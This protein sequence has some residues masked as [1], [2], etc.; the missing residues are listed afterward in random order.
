LSSGPSTEP[1]LGPELA[2]QATVQTHTNPHNPSTARRLS[3]WSSA[4]R[5]AMS[6]ASAAVSGKDAPPVTKVVQALTTRKQPPPETPPARWTRRAVIASFWAVF[7]FLGLP[8]WIK[9]TSIYR[10]VLPL[11]QMT[12]WAEGKV[13]ALGG[14]GFRDTLL[15]PVYRIASLCFLYE[16]LLKHLVYSNGR[17]RTC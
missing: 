14:I 2:L 17:R 7:I 8:I 4:T 1:S 16:L 11:G 15:T 9:T 3:S 6:E 13:R 10:A 12:D 5:A